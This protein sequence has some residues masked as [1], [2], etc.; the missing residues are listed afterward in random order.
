MGMD[1]KG[2]KPKSEAGEYFRNSVL[3][4]RPLWD[5]CQL[6]AP[7]LCAAV[8]YGHSNDGD[9]LGASGARRLA[10]VLD[11][12]IR[13][14]RCES[15][16][17]ARQAQLDALALEDCDICAGTGKRL[18]PPRC[19]AGEEPCNGCA[20]TGKRRPWEAE[21]DFSVENVRSFAACLRDCGGFEIW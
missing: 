4:W 16:A 7:T 19:G 3:G 11:K 13:S 17:K 8:E 21:Y 20:S 14:G 2:V 12:E 15:Y 10:A 6:V 18:P 5:Y 1:V 9:G